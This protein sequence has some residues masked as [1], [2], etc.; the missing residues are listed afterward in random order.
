MGCQQGVS[1]PCCKAWGHTS[2]SLWAE[3]KPWILQ[4]DET[5]W[6]FFF[7]IISGWETPHRPES[8]LWL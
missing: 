6:D 4:A 2:V 8:V 7:I 1:W 5:P 3:D